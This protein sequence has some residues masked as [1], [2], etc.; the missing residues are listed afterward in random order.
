V[1]EMDHPGTHSKF[2]LPFMS[3]LL[4]PS[5][6]FRSALPTPFIRYTFRNHYTREEHPP[7][8]QPYVPDLL[9]ARHNQT[10]P[11]FG[12]IAIFFAHVGTTGTRHCPPQQI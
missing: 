4:C 9:E 10:A 5:R 11:V 12:T 2:T 1:D 6:L 8:S 7:M 3:F